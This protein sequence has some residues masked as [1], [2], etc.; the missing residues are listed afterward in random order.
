MITEDTAVIGQFYFVNRQPPR[1][2]DPNLNLVGRLG[3]CRWSNYRGLCLRFA[4]GFTFVI[5]Y[6][7][8]YDPNEQNAAA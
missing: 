6:D 5:P 4:D 2:G 3:W 8:I 1:I 7:C